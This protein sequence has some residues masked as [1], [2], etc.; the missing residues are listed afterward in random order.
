MLGFTHYWGRSR[1]EYWTVKSKT[2]RDRFTRTV[3]HFNEWCRRNRHLLV[4]DQRAVLNRKF[5]GHD[6]CFGIT[7]NVQA[8]SRLRYE[9][10]LRRRKWLGRRSGAARLN[11]DQFKRLLKRYPLQ[12]ARFNICAPRVEPSHGAGADPSR[13]RC[14]G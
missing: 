13:V 12:P 10:Q 3:R 5:R 6:A 2:V 4:A 14:A 11:W 7:G 8:L 9:V 1:K